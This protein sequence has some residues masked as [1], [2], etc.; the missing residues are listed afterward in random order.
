MQIVNYSEPFPFSIIEDFL[1]EEQYNTVFSEII[2][3]ISFL[4][5]PDK[6]GA[7]FDYIDKYKVYKKQNHGVYLDAVFEKNRQESAILQYYDG[8]YQ[9]HIMEVICQNGWFYEHYFPT[10]NH[11]STLLQMY[12]NGDH[13]KQHKDYTNFTVIG[14]Y[15]TNPK[16]FEGGELRFASYDLDIILEN[17]QVIIFPSQI[18]HEVLPITSHAEKL[19]DNRFTITRF[20]SRTID[21]SYRK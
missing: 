20:I 2:S 18:P 21:L 7:A 17:N 5:T 8:I 16:K 19:Q 4:E 15:H 6:T 12:G 3:L 14:L 10:T 9:K 13:Y 1:N 11:D